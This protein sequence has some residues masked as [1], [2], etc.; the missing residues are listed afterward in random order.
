[1]EIGRHVT[2]HFFLTGSLLSGFLAVCCE[3]WD[4][5]LGNGNT[6]ILGP[7]KSFPYWHLLPGLAGFTFIY[8]IEKRL[9][10]GDRPQQIF[11]RKTD[12]TNF[13]RH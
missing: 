3:L 2:V 11:P 4:T 12:L 10:S 7:D 13:G 5:I 6:M 1:M 8:Q 9:V